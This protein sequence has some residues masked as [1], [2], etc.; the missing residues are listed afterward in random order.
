MKYKKNYI[1]LINKIRNKKEL[2]FIGGLLKKK[3]ILK[4][5]P[6]VPKLKNILHIA[7][8]FILVF[9]NG[10]ATNIYIVPLNVL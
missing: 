8:S 4:F 6:F 9:K 3:I 1:D 10:I 2:N 5:E 7:I